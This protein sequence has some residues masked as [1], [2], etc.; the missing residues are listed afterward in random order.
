MPYPTQTY[1]SAVEGNWTEEPG[2]L[3]TPCLIWKGAPSRPVRGYGQVML[4][5]RRTGVHVAVFEHHYGPV[6]DGMQ[7]NH[8]CDNTMCVNYLHVYAGTHGDN[9]TDRAVRGRTHGPPKGIAHHNA[10]L[11]DAQVQEI[12]DA[13]GLQREIAETFGITQAHVSSI[14]LGRRR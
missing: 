6:P 11:S 3:D 14:K 2:P 10:K 13:E 5:W 4:N 7:V 12:R 8:H 9:M 1:E